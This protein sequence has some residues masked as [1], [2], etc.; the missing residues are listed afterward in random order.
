MWIFRKKNLLG[1]SI[2]LLWFPI[3]SDAPLL[4]TFPCQQPP[5]HICQWS[6]CKHCQMWNRGEPLNL[7]LQS[8]HEDIKTCPSFC[9]AH[10]S[11]S[12]SLPPSSCDPLLSVSLHP[13]PSRFI[14]PLVRS[15][16]ASPF[17]S[18]CT[19]QSWTN[20]QAAGGSCLLSIIQA[21]QTT[22]GMFAK[23]KKIHLPLRQSG[24]EKKRNLVVAQIQHTERTSPTF[25]LQI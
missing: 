10:P 22:V 4:K 13:P 12:L 8:Y 15:A 1:K 9:T 25:S 18:L 17:P 2:T 20:K 19:R 5:R 24:E 16:V 6:S 23:H 11:F 21:R 7:S 3:F 14:P